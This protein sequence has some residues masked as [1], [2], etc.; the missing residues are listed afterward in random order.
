MQRLHAGQTKKRENL[1]HFNYAVVAYYKAD[2]TMNGKSIE[3]V[4]LA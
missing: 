4:N 2:T 1:A 3:Q